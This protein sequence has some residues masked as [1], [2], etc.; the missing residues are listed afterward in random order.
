MNRIQGRKQ[1]CKGM[2]FG[3]VVY[4]VI[5]K[6]IGNHFH[7]YYQLGSKAHPIGYKSVNLGSCK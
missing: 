2:I 6:D 3:I 5:I 1:M 7:Q 4:H